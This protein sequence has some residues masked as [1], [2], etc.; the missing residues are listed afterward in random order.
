MHTDYMTQ[1]YQF[2]LIKVPL[3]TREF[4]DNAI[5]L[6]DGVYEWSFD[7]GL[8]KHKY[9]KE[10]GYIYIDDYKYDVSELKDTIKPGYIYAL[11]NNG[12]IIRLA[13]FKDRYFYKLYPISPFDAP[14][15]EISG[16][17]MHRVEGIKP[18]DDAR[19]KVNTLNISRGENVLD[20]CTGLGYTA[21]H[22]MLKGARVTSIELDINVLDIARF[23]PWSHM[24]E[25]IEIILGDAFEVIRELP[26]GS[27]DAVI[28]DPPRF[29][30]AG[31]LYSLEFYEEI[32]RVLKR[33]GRLF[34][35]TGRV[36][37]KH[38]HI[39][40]MRSVSQRLKMVGFRV[41]PI[42]KLMGVLAFKY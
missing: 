19:L 11:L 35:Y 14:T 20:V 10:K 25:K 17:K 41:R 6:N 36:G 30:R 34:H 26:S 42:P 15:L 3:I 1:L 28:H 4:I 22:S 7:L 31:Q 2:K 32:Y 8:S 40:I 29:S 12:R 24:L 23:N 33:N 9:L 39:D 5:K 38:R 13:Y 37:Y 18:W 27:Y 21:I 16:I